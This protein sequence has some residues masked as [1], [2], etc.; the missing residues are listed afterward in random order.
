MNTLLIGNGDTMGGPVGL[1]NGSTPFLPADVD[2]ARYALAAYKFQ[3][4]KAAAEENAQSYAAFLANMSHELRTPLNAIIGFSELLMMASEE[5]GATDTQADYYGYI[6]EAGT[7]LHAHIEDILR[8]SR[9]NA[10]RLAMRETQV[11]V[12]DIFKM[13][14][15]VVRSRAN[16]ADVYFVVRLPHRE[17]VLWADESQLAQALL[18]MLFCAIK[19]TPRCGKLA[20]GMKRKKD[21]LLT[22]YVRNTGTVGSGDFEVSKQAAQLHGGIFEIE[23]RVGK[24]TR[25]NLRLPRERVVK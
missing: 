14:E 17:T 13:V 12:D 25:L 23:D 21:G 18:N 20:L 5:A 10:Q 11:R 7:V 15:Q 6:H 24:G 22:L 4:V 9:V 8:I 2:V 3:A 1:G 16:R 19:K